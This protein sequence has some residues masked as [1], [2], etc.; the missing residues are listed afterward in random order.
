MAMA[1]GGCAPSGSNKGECVGRV[2]EQVGN[3]KP[4]R[5]PRGGGRSRPMRPQAWRPQVRF[6][7]TLPLIG[8]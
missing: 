1:C 7:L 5:P 6:V 2:R 8:K 3:E 4:P